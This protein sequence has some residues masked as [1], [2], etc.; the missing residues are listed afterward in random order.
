M[1]E[2]R[3]GDRVF[4]TKAAW[5]ESYDKDANVHRTGG[6]E[7]V[8][9]KVSSKDV[10]VKFLSDGLKYDYPRA[11]A[12]KKSL[13]PIRIIKHTTPNNVATKFRDPRGEI[14]IR[15]IKNLTRDTLI[16]VYPGRVYTFKEYEAL[17]N[18]G[19]TSDKYALELPK[20]QSDGFIDYESY[21][22]DPGVGTGLDSDFKDS[23][24]PFLNEPGPHTQANCYWV[25][26]IRDP[27]NINMR[28]YTHEPVKK[29][30]ELT[31]CY[32]GYYKRKYK[33]SC[34]S[35]SPSRGYLMRTGDPPKQFP[36]TDIYW[37]G[38][39]WKKTN[40]KSSS[41]SQTTPGVSSSH[42]T[43][44]TLKRAASTLLSQQKRQ[45]T[46]SP[47]NRLMM[48]AEYI[49]RS[50]ASPTRQPTTSFQ[51]SQSQSFQSSQSLQSTTPPVV[52]VNT[53][54]GPS[55]SNSRMLVISRNHF[56]INQFDERCKPRKYL[57]DALVDN[58]L[59]VKT[60][61][62]SGSAGKPHDE[63]LW[64]TMW[65]LRVKAKHPTITLKNAILL[66]RQEAVHYTGSKR[67]ALLEITFKRIKNHIDNVLSMGV[68]IGH[69]FPN[70]VL[71]PEGKKVTWSILCPNLPTP[72]KP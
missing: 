33:T 60:R 62:N 68:K 19:L 20:L 69:R 31:V 4:E 10:T 61:Q 43:S 47:V 39:R 41:I 21:I 30:E 70:I 54:P 51:S 2:L 24:G 32:G 67:K 3:A 18:R 5:P 48:L 27:S 56:D 64:G 45:K 28:I 13:R 66:A 58:Y 55:G 17:Q 25:V 11:D 53:G 35:N 26:D 57:F 71:T 9:E 37:N 40:K 16:D 50:S 29:D 52:S 22:V 44:S 34:V 6:F 65:I 36:G 7:G 72:P 59:A 1:R 49:N 38:M 12:E 63:S 46:Q 23:I 14:G 42:R 8:V 15:A